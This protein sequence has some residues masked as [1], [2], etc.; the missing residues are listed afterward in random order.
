MNKRI[1]GV[2]LAVIISV[3]VRQVFIQINKNKNTDSHVYSDKTEEF[4]KKVESYNHYKHCI[5]LISKIDKKDKFD[6]LSECLCKKEESIRYL[7]DSIAEYYKPNL[8]KD[9]VGYEVMVFMNCMIDS[10]NYYCFDP[11]FI[12]NI[13]FLNI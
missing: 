3:I 8:L 9:E 2:V 13:N 7:E 10:K 6:D 4:F 11:I 5:D 12:N 1:S